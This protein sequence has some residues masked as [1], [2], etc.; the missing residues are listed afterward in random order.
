MKRHLLRLAAVLAAAV[1]VAALAQQP[2]AKPAAPEPHRQITVYGFGLATCDA[3]QQLQK[4][5]AGGIVDEWLLGYLSGGAAF[6]GAN[7]LTNIDMFDLLNRLR[8]YCAANPR[9]VLAQAGIEIAQQLN[10]EAS[11]PH[12]EPKPG[13]K[14]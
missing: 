4:V 1:P 9:T 10:N 13:A 5:G 2:P 7:F 11:K 8:D 6:T 14:K 3:W 12:A